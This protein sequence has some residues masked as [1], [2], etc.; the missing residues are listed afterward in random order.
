MFPS[1][2]PIAEEDAEEGDAEEEE[3]EEE[4]KDKDDGQIAEYV[5]ERSGRRWI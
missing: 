4:Y 1:L 2:P 5:R 3:E